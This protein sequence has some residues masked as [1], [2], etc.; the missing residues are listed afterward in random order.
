MISPSC[1]RDGW[2]HVYAVSR[3]GEQKLLT[4]GPFD[5]IDVAGIDEAGGRLYYYASPDN[6][7]QKYLY[8]VDLDGKNARRVTPAASKG[9][10][11]YQLSPDGRWAIHTH[12]SFGTP[13]VIDLVRLP[14]HQVVEGCH[15]GC[16]PAR[17][18]RTEGL[19][20]IA[21]GPGEGAST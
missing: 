13:P 21:Q 16:D 9:T 4:P 14:E 2:K 19:P 11:D 17:V 20:Y 7:T 8:A 18:L 15:Y 1:E 5:V 3:S 6:A 12:S 10:H